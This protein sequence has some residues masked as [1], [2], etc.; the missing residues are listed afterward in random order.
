MTYRA[1]QR[2]QTLSS[3]LW[4]KCPRTPCRS[5]VLGIKNVDNLRFGYASFTFVNTN[6]LCSYDLLA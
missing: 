4:P 5:S 2:L 6:F 3:Q 1:L